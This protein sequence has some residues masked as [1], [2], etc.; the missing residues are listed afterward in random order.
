MNW[1]AKG[2]HGLIVLSALLLFSCEN[3]DLLSLDFDPQDENINLSFTELTLPFQLVQRD[4]VVTTNAERILVGDYRNEDFGLVKATGYIN[5][6]ISSGAVNNADDDDELDSLVLIVVK[7]YFYGDAGSNLQQTIHIHQLSEP[8]NDTISYYQDSS[9]PYDAMY[10]GA[11]SFTADA[12]EPADTLRV[13]LSN[14]VGNDFL[15]KLKSD[16]AELDSSALFEDYFKGLALV[17]S[18]EN[19]FASGFSRVQMV[20]YFSAPADTASK[21][22]SFT[23]SRIFNGV[24]IDR[25]G[26]AIAN[27]N[28]PQQVGSATDNRFYL[29]A[30]TGLIPRIDFQPLVEFVESN[31]D[32]VLLNRVVLRIG[33]NDFNENMAPPAA[34]LGYQLQDDGISRITSYDSQQRQYFYV[35]AYND[36]D[37]VYNTISKQPIPVRPS[38]IV[39]DSTNVA[40]EVKLTSFSQN[41]IDGFVDNPQVLLYPNDISNG[42][43]QVTTEADSIKLRV[44]YTTLK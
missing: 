16:A 10:L 29:Q 27:I 6:G 44:Y 15:E 9:L 40:Y 17:P 3:E 13:G 37:Y 34:L 38:S 31:P 36:N 7:D 26:T 11:L 4:S 14:A 28:Q 22:F 5:M 24:E 43:T 33:L 21:S 19:S 2:K 18:S 12:E 41:L 32:R 23:A 30:T 25:S 42:L 39:Y 8:F 1:L 20:M 35:G